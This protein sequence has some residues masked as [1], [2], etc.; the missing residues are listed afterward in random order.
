RD[1]LNRVMAASRRMGELIDDLLTLSRVSRGE[2]T[3]VGVDLSEVARDIAGALARQAPGRAVEWLIAPGLRAEGDARLLRVVLE[4]LLGNA[5]KYTSKKSAARIEFG[6]EG[7][8][9]V[10]RDDGA[11]FDPRYAGKLFQ[12][13]QRLHRADEFDGHGVGLATVKRVVARHGGRVWADG[14]PGEGAAVYFSVGG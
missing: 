13:F 2:M 3:R 4:N 12:P 5:W 8:A 14:R 6:R 11:G 1:S 10:V 7:D 9:F